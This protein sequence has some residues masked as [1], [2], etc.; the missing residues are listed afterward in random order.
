MLE[1]LDPVTFY[2]TE[3]VAGRTVAGP[4]VRNTCKRHLRDIQTAGDRGLYFDHNAVFRIFRF[5]EK[6]L[7][8]SDGQFEGKPFK[9][10]ISQKFIIGSLYG[11][12][13]KS[14]DKRRFRRAYIEMGKGNGK[15]LSLDT[16]IPTPDGFKTMGD[17]QVGDYVF[18]DDGSPT[19]IIK[20][21]EIMENH[22]CYEVT[23]SDGEKIIADAGHLWKTSALRTGLSKG[24][25]KPGQARK[26]EYSLRTTDEIFASC[27]INENSNSK[28]P[29]AKYNHRVDFSGPLNL[30][31]RDL[32]IKPYTLGVWLGD[33]DSDNS[34]ITC[35][36]KDIETIEN[37]KRDGYPIT[38][39]KKHSETTGRFSI[40]EGGSGQGRKNTV[41]QKLRENKLLNNKHIPD[42]YLRASYEQRL[43]LL[44]GLMDSDGTISKS[45]QC[46]F[47]TIKE[48]ISKGFVHLLYTLGIKPSV[49]IKPAMLNGVFICDK[50]RIT[51]YQSN[52]IP[53]FKLSRK[54]QR[55]KE[56][57]KTRKLSKGRQIV[58]CTPVQSV[59]TKCISVEADSSMF[60]CGYSMIPTHNSPTCAGIALFGMISDGEPGAQIYAAGSDR[61]QSDIMFQ[62]AVKMAKAS[63]T[64]DELITYGGNQKVFNMACLGPKQA[65]SFFRPLAKTAG[66][67]GSGYRPHYALIDELHEHPDRTVMDLLERGFKFREQ[68]L[69]LMVT[70][71]GSDRNSICFEEHGYGCKVAAGDIE[72]DRAFSYICALDEKDDWKDPDVWIK[73]NP[74]L[75]VTITKEYLAEQVKMAVNIPGKANGIKR[76]H[77]CIW[78]DA[79]NAWMTRELWEAI[80]DPEMVMGQFIG[81]PCHVG[82]DL[83]SKRDLTA[84]VT[85][86]ED[87]YTEPYVEPDTGDLIKPKKKYAMFAHGYT[88]KGTLKERV[89]ED[90]AP[91]DQWVEAGF[92]TATPGKVIDFSYVIK[93]IVE[94]D[95]FFEL[96]TVAYDRYMIKDFADKMDEMNVDFPTIE[97]A[98]GWSMR[99]DTPLWMPGSIKTLEELI[100]EKRLRVHVNPALRSAVA[101][102]TFLE[103]STGI[104]RFAKQNALQRIDLIVA[105]AMAIG[106]IT[107][108]EKPEKSGHEEDRDD[109]H[110]EHTTNTKSGYED[111]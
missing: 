66:K 78:T 71:S 51:F 24:P 92:L 69:L 5:F 34:R 85:V 75:G 74:L 20:T 30:P 39:N 54:L 56:P 47:T 68:P 96:V 36:F 59:P 16:V 53:V 49:S 70:N 67:S 84:R 111:Y 79:E 4:H 27:I 43:E 57:P 81:E 103:S 45:G 48:E 80:E 25:R 6:Y 76:L 9:L 31:E 35:A 40:S 37:I 2:A 88:P 33:G 107:H 77:F 17:L 99:K 19:R 21:S 60:L 3:V 7:K 73:A 44:R 110:H 18:A 63:P 11:W 32:P 52:D 64:I 97:H 86:F 105:A 72:D 82:L 108:T 1:E 50:Y 46:E 61:N 29:Q 62:D 102:A 15:A 38:Q 28:H 101:G 98:Q 42:I 23:F 94:T 41:R 12:K 58:S 14:D 106:S 90:K 100:L 13:R 87:G 83:S 104:K 8:L 109:E 65:G 26:G 89:D 93:D 91:Y 10:H 95:Q 22:D 55:Q